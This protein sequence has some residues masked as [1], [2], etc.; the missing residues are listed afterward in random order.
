M[1]IKAASRSSGKRGP[2]ERRMSDATGYQQAGAAIA[3]RAPR[4]PTSTSAACLTRTRRLGAP[5]NH[6]S[7]RLE[8]TGFS[9]RSSP[10]HRT[11]R[12]S[13]FNEKT[14][15]HST[16]L[17]RLCSVPLLHPAVSQATARNGIFARNV[18]KRRETYARHTRAAFTI[19]KNRPKTSLSAGR[20]PAA[21]FG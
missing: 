18:P 7:L 11:E 8:D 12:G 15:S 6:R 9:L 1:P 13:G 10:F 14:G 4:R 5:P 19:A 17:A 21:S 20:S 16:I 2:Q 3:G